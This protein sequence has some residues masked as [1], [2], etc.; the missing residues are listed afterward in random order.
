[1]TS[2][3]PGIVL[4]R[5]VSDGEEV[6]PSR[7]E[8]HRL[9]RVLRLPEGAAVRGLAPDG[10]VVM[11]QMR[12]A[13]GELRL[14]AVGRE[15]LTAPSSEGLTVAMALIKR[16]AHLDFVIEKGTELGV[17]AWWA[18]VSEHC[19]DAGLVRSY[20]HRL[21]RWRR[22]A[23]AA[24]IQCGRP[25]VPRVRGVLSWEEFLQEA[26]TFG[27]RYFA[28]PRAPARL[29]DACEEASS[30]TLFLVGPEGGWSRSEEASLEERGFMPVDL[31]P[32]VLRSETAA[33]VGSVLLAP[34]SL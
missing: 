30:S 18:V 24:S 4:R 15:A 13:G 8:A 26:P 19:A 28:V 25:A 11:L 14:R 12:S 9:R 33:L 2:H 3:V 23:E 1:M 22:I 32:T 34:K 17:S 31:G 27:R 7:A 20:L 21:M 6:V 16:A 10:A 5:N 29:R